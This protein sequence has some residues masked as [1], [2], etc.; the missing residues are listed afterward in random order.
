MGDERVLRAAEQ[1]AEARG[2]GGWGAA[3]QRLGRGQLR[4][5]HAGAAA[6]RRSVHDSSA[7]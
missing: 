2:G 4:G 3:R 1:G 5:G 7:T 6:W